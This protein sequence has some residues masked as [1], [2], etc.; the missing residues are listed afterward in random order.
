MAAD[1]V[2]LRSDTVTV[3]TPAMWEAMAHAEVGDDVYGEDP[4]IN[5]LQKLA[6][7]KMGKEAGLF[8]PSGTMGNL[9]AVLVHC[10]RGDEAIMGNF[11]HT[12]LFEAGGIS[13]LGGVMAHT[14]PNQADGTLLLEDIQSAIRGDDPHC[15][16][17]KLVILENTHNRCGGVPI[18]AEFT[19]KVADLAHSRGIKLHV[20]GARIFNAAVASGVP[21]TQLVEPADSVTFCLS[22]A[23]CAPVGSV[24][25]GSAEFIHQAHRIRKQLGGGM[26]QAGVLA[27]AGIVALQTMVERLAEDHARARVLADGLRAIPGLILEPALPPSNMVFVDL[28]DQVPFTAAE[29]AA[30]LKSLGIKVGAA[31]KRRFRLVTHYWVDDAGIEKTIASYKKVLAEA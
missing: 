5:L 1:F 7:D 16:V 13:A 19:R 6:A 27:A 23:L 9:A 8:V 29:V 15:P 30:K 18:T 31:G 28:S 20:D 2:D 12:F 4:S 14:L 26:R 3:P 17:S 24:L 22:K 11:G 25:C 21:V 10:G